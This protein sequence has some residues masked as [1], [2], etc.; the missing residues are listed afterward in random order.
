MKLRKIV[1]LGLG[2]PAAMLMGA[3]L[4]AAPA[5]TRATEPDPAVLGLWLT[6]KKGLVVDLYPCGD[7]ICG[8]IAWLRKPTWKS[9]GELRRDTKNPDPMLR[10]RA[11]CGIE[12][13]QGL[14]ADGDGLWD[15][16]KFYNPKDGGTYS[17]AIEPE[18]DG[19]LKARGYLGIKLLGKSETWARPGPD[20]K[21]H[22]L[23]EG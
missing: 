7:E 3:W 13:I 23:P 14:E 22:C 19:T 12:V 2:L 1:T 18:A 9:T 5:A 10:G 6:E 16:G 21:P 8:R 11:W 17:L 20:I 15:N 4:V